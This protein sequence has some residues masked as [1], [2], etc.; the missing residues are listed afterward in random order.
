MTN[1]DHTTHI[2]SDETLIRMA[3]DG[4]LTA[5]LSARVDALRSSD[6]SIDDRI[7]AHKALRESV[8]RSLGKPESAPAGLR[9]RIAS[10][11]SAVPDS[12]ITPADPI[13][14]NPANTGAVD[15]PM[16]NTRERS[17]W[18]RVPGMLAVA[19]TLALVASV[20]IVSFSA[21][22]PLFADRDYGRQ[23]V[24]FI[25]HEHSGCSEFKEHFERKF[26]TRSLEDARAL[27]ERYFNQSVLALTLD[28]Q[29][30]ED[31][32]FEFMGFGP[33]AVPGVL[34]SGHIILK[35]KGD[36]GNVVSLFVHPDAGQLSF[37]SNSCCYVGEPD[38]SDMGQI[39]A[40][41]ADGMVYYLYGINEQ[42]LQAARDLFSTPENEHRLL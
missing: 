42:S 35:E 2:P 30:W 24:N 31:A 33:C 21:T 12:E 28:E 27:S 25:E 37:K 40:W 16:G 41:K 5:E 14:G 23:V 29:S 36:G 10:A 4:E 11:M 18:S 20:L 38:G 15:T 3:A 22:K 1:N 8:A 32:S 7:E 6:P 34:R 13:T 9:D 39:I 19:A 26:V 17:F